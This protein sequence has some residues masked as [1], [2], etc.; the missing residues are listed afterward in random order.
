MLKSILTRLSNHINLLIDTRLFCLIK[1]DTHLRIVRFLCVLGLSNQLSQLSITD[2]NEDSQRR[3]NV[4]RLV[5]SRLPNPS[6]YHYEWQTMTEPVHST[7]HTPRTHCDTLPLSLYHPVFAQFVE[8][9]NSCAPDA[10][11]TAF[12]VEIT[13]KMC[14]HYTYKQQRTDDFDELFRSY[15]NMPMTSVNYAQCSTDSTINAFIGRQTVMLLNRVDRAE[16]GRSGDSFMQNAAY[17]AHWASTKSN[18]ELRSRTSCPVFLMDLVGPYVSVSGGMLLDSHFVS[19][20]TPILRLFYVH[21]DP[22][23]LQ[24]ARFFRALKNGVHSLLTFYQ[25]ALKLPR[26]SLDPPQFAFPY[27]REYCLSSHNVRFTYQRAINHRVFVCQVS[28]VE[29]KPCSESASQSSNV[30]ESQQINPEINETIIVKFV[31]YYGSEAHQILA[32][33]NCAPRLYA[34]VKLVPDWLMVVM[35]QVDGQTLYDT[36]I[37]SATFNKLSQALK[38]LHAANLVHGDFR[39]SNVMVSGSEVYVIDFDWSGEHE[40]H[41]YPYFMSKTIPWPVEVADNAIMK[42]EHDIEMLNRLKPSNHVNSVETP[43]Y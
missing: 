3:D 1:L 2:E 7:L 14:A 34:V 37:T 43:Q 6:S 22:S 15:L 20:L 13:A 19:P 17:Y 18:A 27:H 8:D 10:V 29:E 16:P 12:V 5:R 41:R 33:V 21:N 30:Q 11:D 24:L 4:S 35:S 42:I 39:P 26:P 38:H 40:K 9:C 36:R 25:Q 23:N 28:S 31:R 32:D